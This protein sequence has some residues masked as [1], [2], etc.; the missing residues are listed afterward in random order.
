MA[1]AC[2]RPPSLFLSPVSVC[3]L[4]G[5][6]DSVREFCVQHLRRDWCRWTAGMGW[7]GIGVGCAFEG[8]GRPALAN[9]E[10]CGLQSLALHTIR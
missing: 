8:N 9:R 10:S 1:A 3:D 6:L 4:D 2:R 5:G 7:T